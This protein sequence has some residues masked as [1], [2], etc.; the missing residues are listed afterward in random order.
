MI[1]LLWLGSRT[2]HGVIRTLL[3]SCYWRY[4]RAGE[5]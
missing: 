1:A 5:G 4:V 3:L 2:P